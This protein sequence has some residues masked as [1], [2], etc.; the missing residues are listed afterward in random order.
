MH[1]WWCLHTLDWRIRW[2]RESFSDNENEK[3]KKGITHIKTDTQK[4]II[5]VI[6]VSNKSYLLLDLRCCLKVIFLL[7]ENI[8]LC[9]FITEFFKYLLLNL[10]NK[11][12]FLKFGLHLFQRALVNKYF[13]PFM[14][15]VEKWPNILKKFFA[16]FTA[17]DFW[18]CL[19][20]FQHYA[21]KD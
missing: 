7:T 17:Q 11:M 8:F 4:L 3:S 2:N 13:K 9:T 20:I 12:G 19:T 14:H 16:V 18:L 10:N 6:K 15:N 1:L 21:W 5:K